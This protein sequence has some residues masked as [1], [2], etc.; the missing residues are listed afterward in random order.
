MKITTNLTHIATEVEFEPAL[1]EEQL[2]EAF[3]AVGL[4]GFPAELDIAERTEEHVQMMALDS[5]LGFA[6]TSGVAAVT[7]DVTYFPHADDAEVTY[8]LK[9]LARE[10]EIS[11]DV[12]RDVC[13]DEIR[14]YLELD[15]KRD[16]NAPVHSIVECYVGGTAF[17]WYGM[18]EYP[19]LKR[20]ILRKLAQGG[21]RAK[22]NFI[23][24][25]S[26]AQVDLLEDY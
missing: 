26:K 13:A 6:Q 1:T 8:Q 15:A 21:Q 12:I 18:N 5:F 7:Y 9:Q 4:K 17:A 22:H 25:A 14:E 3:G 2:K 11:A 19:R 16:A 10:L 23:M 20:V 24:R